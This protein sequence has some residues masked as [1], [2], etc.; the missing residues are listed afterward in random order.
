MCVIITKAV[1]NVR[2]ASEGIDAGD[3][4]GAAGQ[5]APEF[6]ECGEEV[7]LLTQ[8]AVGQDVCCFDGAEAVLPA[9]GHHG[10]L[11]FVSPWLSAEIST[12]TATG[13]PR[14]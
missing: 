1:P 6:V 3:H 2:V 10:G 14:R 9:R 12:H 5:D 11:E 8:T 4:A 7:E 13:G